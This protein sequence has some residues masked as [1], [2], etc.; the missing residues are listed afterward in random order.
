MEFQLIQKDSTTKARAGILKTAHSTM[1]TPC[2][3]PVGTQATVKTLSPEELN[4]AGVKAILC[5]TYHLML[6]PGAELIAKAGGLHEFMKWN[7]TILTDSG[8][9]QVFSLSQLRKVSKEG[10]EF[11]SHIDGTKYFLTPQEAM[12]IQGL[13]GS[14]I[15]LCLDECLSYP[16]TFDST[17]NSIELTLKWAEICKEAHQSLSSKQALFAIVQGS[18]FKDLRLKCSE[19]LVQIGFD[20]YAL[21]GLS[22]GEPDLVMYEVLN[23][24]VEILPCTK[25]RYLMGCGTPQNLLECVERGIDIFDCVL[26]TR[27]ARNGTVFTREGKWNITNSCFKE[28]FSPLDDQCTCY[29]CKKFSRSYLR[30]LFNAGEILGLRLASLH[31]IAFYINLMKETRE[32]ILAGTFSEFKSNFLKNFS[33]KEINL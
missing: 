8:G 23:D 4:S 17:C 25:P 24:T 13:L 3:M 29:T 9:F 5:N 11:K 27:N 7:G 18:V 28:D 12:R 14:D 6:R 31:N 32:S 22:V 33:Q 19:G 10:V 21:G 16:A 20:G 15:A 30:H 2:F 1:E 26:P